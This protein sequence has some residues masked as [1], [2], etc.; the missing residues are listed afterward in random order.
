MKANSRQVGM[1][2]TSSP[3][4]DEKAVYREL[5]GLRVPGVGGRPY[6]FRAQTLGMVLANVERTDS[7]APPA[8]HE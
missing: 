5:A 8:G 7:P 4:N 3:V 6:F 1:W 2:G